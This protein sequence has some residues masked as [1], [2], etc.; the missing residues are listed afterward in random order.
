MADHDD[1]P[2]MRRRAYVTE[3]EAQGA[4]SDSNPYQLVNADQHPSPTITIDTTAVNPNISTEP[5]QESHPSN[6]QDDAVSPTTIADPVSTSGMSQRPS[7]PELDTS[8]AFENRDSRPTSPHNVSSP[9][10]S[11]SG[12]RG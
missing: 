12:E 5:P 9:V 3:A 7:R 4:S 11:R 1:H 2:P 6:M 8:M 10:T